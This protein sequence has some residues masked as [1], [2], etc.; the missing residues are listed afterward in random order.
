MGDTHLVEDGWGGHRILQG[1]DGTWTF[2]AAVKGYSPKNVVLEEYLVDN[3]IIFHG[4]LEAPEDGGVGIL[5]SGVRTNIEIGKTGLITAYRG[6]ELTGT[7]QTLVN[8]GMIGGGNNAI[9]VNAINAKVVN[10]GIMQSDV[11]AGMNSYHGLFVNNGSIYGYDALNLGGEDLRVVL[12][13]TSVVSGE[14][15]GIDAFGDSGET[16]TIINRGLISGGDRALSLFHADF[17]L[18]NRGQIDGDVVTFDGNSTF[19]F[20]GGALNG[21]IYGGDGDDTYILSSLKTAVIE[22]A[23]KGYDT[24]KSTLSYD[25]ST[26]VNAAQEIEALKLIGKDNIDATGD[27][28]Y[29]HLAGNSGDNVLS[30]GGGIDTLDGGKGDDTLVG[31]LGTDYFTFKTGGG[32]DVVTDFVPY[33]DQFDFTGWKAIDG[34]ED[35]MKH[36]VTVEHGD[37]VITG[38]QDSITLEG[39]HKGDLESIDFFF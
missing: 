10:N 31:G 14:R 11:T 25:L 23:D 15:D 2:T 29:N 12:N 3:T 4:K 34:F 32:H 21:A 38:G 9:I 13:K 22:G 6:V 20:R 26:G 17:K 28:G 1:S 35:M 24:I 27:D 16:I 5:S 37:V 8:N 39:V 19:D 7:D 30:G 33:A 18:V 36:H